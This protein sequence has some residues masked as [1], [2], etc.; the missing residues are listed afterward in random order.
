MSLQATLTRITQL[1][2]QGGFSSEAKVSYN[3]VVPI[4][5]A[6]QWN[7][8]DPDIVIPEYTVSLK[9]SQGRVDFALRLAPRQ[10]PV[11]F[12]EVKKPTSEE[13]AD[14]LLE[15]AFK[16]GGVPIAVLTNGRVSK[17]YLPGERG[18]FQ[19]RQ[20]YKLDLFQHSVEE[21][22]EVF[23]RFLHRDRVVS[24][25]ALKQAKEALSEKTKNK[26]IMQILPQAWRD[27]LEESDEP[28]RALLIE[29]IKSLCGHVPSHKTIADFLQQEHQSLQIP[30][31]P[32]V[33]PRTAENSSFYQ[34]TNIPTSKIQIIGYE[35]DGTRH[36][37]LSGATTMA[38]I[39]N[40]F[41]RRDDTFLTHLQAQISQKRPLVSPNRNTLSVHAVP[42]PLMN[43]WWVDTNYTSHRKE[44]FI[45]IA[46]KIMGVAYQQNLKLLHKQQQQHQALQIPPAP[47]TTPQTVKNSN[48]DEPANI[49]SSKT[50]IIGYELDGNRHTNL[51]GSTTMTAIFDEFQ[52]RDDTF[53]TRLQAR[54]SQKRLLVSPNRNTLSVHAVPKRLMNGW[55]VD[56]HYNSA[57]KEKF[58]KIACEIMGVAYQ[59]NLKLIHKLQQQNQ[60]SQI[61][62][63]SAVARRAAKNSSPKNSSPYKPVNRPPSKV[64]I[65]GYELN[66]ERHTGLIG[67]TTMAAIFNEFQRRDDTFLTRLRAR[68]SGGKRQLVSPNKNRLPM[69]SQNTVKKLKN[70]W[71]VNTHYSSSHKENFIKVACEIMEITY[72]RDLKLLWE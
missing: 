53:L 32:A 28:L 13:G 56:T 49:P 1:L 48:F 6:L 26:E 2:R 7:T 3:I 43:G 15:Y 17:F 40:E 70:G 12:I 54:T 67:N 30:S 47:A 59:Q 41:Q 69:Y 38:A 5:R 19:E 37:D 39:F 34:P 33:A 29:K 27:L 36:T 16:H 11:V 72:N 65:I 68:T 52:R 46:C 24:G 62:P 8:D 9:G 35:L 50:R 25:A 21:A 61:P 22:T 60:S 51:I 63:V 64:K 45:K 42:K 58:V 44:E 57:N 4:L 20:F 55:W 23:S 71:W 14:Q 10:H 18:N 66:G 31:A